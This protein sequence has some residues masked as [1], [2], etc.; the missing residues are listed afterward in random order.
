MRWRGRNG[1]EETFTLIVNLIEVGSSCSFGTRT[2]TSGARA[3][4]YT[5][6]KW[7]ISEQ[8]RRE[9]AQSSRQSQAARREADRLA[10][11]L[12]AVDVC[13]PYDP[14]ADMPQKKRVP[15]TSLS[16][17]SGG[18]GL[19]LGFDRAGFSHSASYEVLDFAG[20]TLSH[21]RPNWR[22][23]FGEAGDV[24][25]ASWKIYSGQV[26]LV[27]GGPPCQPFSIAGRRKG[28]RDERNMFPEFFRAVK[29]ISPKVFLFENVP[30]FLSRSFDQYR[31]MLISEARFDYHLSLFT[32]SAESFGVP[33]KRK[34]AFCVGVRKDFSS[35]FEA[36]RIAQSG[37]RR[38]VREAL[39]LQSGPHDAPAPTLRSTLTGPR[40]TTSIANSTASVRTWK[41][42]GVWPH[43]I[44][45][46]RSTAASFPTKDGTYRLCVE[47]CQ[48]LQG[49]PLDWQFEGAVYQRLG[50][51]GNSVCPPVAYAVA[52]EIRRQV[53]KL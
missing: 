16:L 14:A 20:R 2:R 9:Y 51:I 25:T 47:E 42:M 38:G 34:R 40:Q 5:H 22:V 28:E 49:F 8:R 50:M 21:N 27:H 45:P 43:G 12:G 4:G 30:G 10:R 7:Q 52:S 17:F 32:L 53:F 46:D 6:I 3:M 41:S 26:D 29:E 15:I 24:R 44:S 11:E 35:P 13:A 18:G 33:Q 1:L 23:F 19:D 48:L 36:E 39:G 31:E 37:S